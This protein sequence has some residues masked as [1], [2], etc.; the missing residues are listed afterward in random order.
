MLI[1]FLGLAGLS[2]DRLYRQ[3]SENALRELLDAQMVALIAAAEPGSAPNTLT[4]D[5]TTEPRLQTPGSGLFAEIRGA[6]A[7]VVWRSGSTAGAF[8]DLTRSVP[9][10]QVL[11]ADIQGGQGEPLLGIWRGLRWQFA[12][13]VEQDLVFAVAASRRPG[14][15]ALAQLRRNLLAGS[16][17]FAAI[18]LGVLLWVTR[19]DDAPDFAHNQS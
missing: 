5:G 17:V 7:R 6:D 15:A 2:L 18:L 12:P 3:Q 19:H 11:Y 4:A 8:I 1:V 16:A 10:G 9:I 13:G 14:Q